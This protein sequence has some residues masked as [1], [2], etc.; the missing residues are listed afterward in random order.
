MFQMIYAEILAYYAFE[1]KSS[2]ICEYQPDVLDDNM[3][4][5]NHEKCSYPQKLN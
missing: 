5:N 1:K 4:E 3:I 2:N